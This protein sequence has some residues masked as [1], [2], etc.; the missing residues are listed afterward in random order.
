MLA[1]GAFFLIL[2]KNGGYMTKIRTTIYL[3]QQIKR[4]LKIY[5]AQSDLSVSQILEL[6]V[7]KYLDEIIQQNRQDQ[8]VVNGS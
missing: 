6:A 2:D 3:D 7:N 4:E 8:R 5:S 1:L